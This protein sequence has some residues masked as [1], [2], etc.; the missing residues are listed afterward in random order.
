MRGDGLLHR[1]CATTS[2]DLYIV[3]PYHRV[4]DGKTSKRHRVPLEPEGDGYE[5]SVLN[6]GLLVGKDLGRRTELFALPMNA[7][8]HA[9]GLA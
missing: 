6:G 8:K 2:C 4:S 5:L 3:I 1:T 7:S 9:A